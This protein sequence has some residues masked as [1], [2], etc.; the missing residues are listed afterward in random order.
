MHELTCPACNA[1][2]KYDLADYIH[3]CPICSSSFLVD[4]E[5]GTKQQYKHHYIVPNQ[6]DASRVQQTMNEWIKRLHHKPNQVKNEFVISEIVGFS[7]P[8]W[9]ISTEVHTRWKGFVRRNKPNP[10]DPNPGGSYLLEEGVFSK[11]YRWCISARENIF[12]KWGLDRLHSPNEKIKITWD[13]FP[14]D[15]TLSRGLLEEQRKSN[16]VRG[17]PVAAQP[18]FEKELFDFK[19]SNGVSVLGIQTTEEE[20]MRRAERHIG[21]YHDKIAE[22]NVDTL[23]DVRN[24]FDIAGIELIHLP[25][26]FGKYHYRPANLLA[27]FKKQNEKNIVVEGFSSGVLTGEFI[28]TKSDR[29]Q[30]NAYVAI[31]AAIVLFLFGAIMHPA[32]FILSL[33]AITVAVASFQISNN[34]KDLSSDVDANPFSEGVTNENLS[35]NP[36]K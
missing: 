9:V 28:M 19:Y 4:F 32:F 33:I 6:L 2:S 15:S 25:M 1:S 10:M 14:L 16:K 23:I 3:I 17:E 12:E 26:W 11:K 13:G 36:V 29:L 21:L 34:R 5:D 7:L 20:A 31:A 27:L 8:F 22:L 35:S 24:E 18:Y 30:I